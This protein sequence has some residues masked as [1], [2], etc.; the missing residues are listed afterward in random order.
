MI[1]I[2]GDTHNSLD[3]DRLDFFKKR[4]DAIGNP[5]IKNDKLII[6]GDFGIP[7]VKVDVLE[8]MI[9]EYKK[10]LSWVQQINN[11]EML[12]EYLNEYPCEILFVDGNHE[13]F[14]VYDELPEEERHGSIVGKMSDN[15]Y[16]LKRGNVYNLDDSK[17]FVFGGAK[18]IDKSRRTEHLSWW[19]REIPSEEEIENGWNN[20]K[21]HDFKVDFVITH[22]LPWSI[23]SQCNYDLA[24]GIDPHKLDD[25]VGKM[26]DSYLDKIKFNMWYVGHMHIDSPYHK[27]QLCYQY[28]Y[29]M[30]KQ[31]RYGDE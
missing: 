1:Y 24:M 12:I 11:D 31:T 18:S 20:L 9:P 14:D 13:N 3:F 23:L 28:F 17:V 25:P 5:L 22:T 7:W 30:K 15:I 21:L 29:E 10:D 4:M 6:A 2:T 27:F 8:K 26:L 19:A 16:H